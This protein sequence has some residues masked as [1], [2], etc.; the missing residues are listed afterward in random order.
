MQSSSSF[1]C[2][3]GLIPVVRGSGVVGLFFLTSIAIF[4]KSRP[5]SG[6]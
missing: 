3:S 6:L 5:G 4:A 2:A 1:N